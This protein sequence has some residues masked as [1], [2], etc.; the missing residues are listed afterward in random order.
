MGDDERADGRYRLAERRFSTLH[1]PWCYCAC[2]YF[3]SVARK[4]ARNSL[5]SGLDVLVEMVLPPIMS[6]IVARA[7]GPAKLG[8]FSYIVWLS[9]TAGMLSAAGIGRAANTFMAEYAGKQRP[10]V[11]RALLRT[12]V[13]FAIVVQAFITLLAVFWV[14]LASP[15]DERLFGSL[16]MLSIFPSGLMC[17]AT[18]VNNAVEE[19]RPNVVA[20]I[21]SGLVHTAGLLLVLLLDW[22]LVGLAA[23]MLASR[24]CDC[25]VR[26]KL[27]Y[28]RLPSYLKAMGSDPTPPGQKPTLPP[29]L[30]RQVAVFVAEA[31]VLT[32]LN[33][34][35]WN[36]SEMFFLKRYAPIEQVAYFSVAFGLSVLPGQLVGPFSRAAGVSV[37][38]ERGRD[39]R[40]GLRVTQV[41][42]RYLVLLVMPTCFGLS[43]LSGPFLRVLYG[44]RYFDAAPVLMWAGALSI[45][46]P[47]ASPATALITA[48]GGQRWLVISGLGTAVA[49]LTLDYVLVRG[50]A[51]VG[52]ALANGLGQAIAT[53]VT[54][55]IA[56]RYSFTFSF[57]YLVRVVAAALGMTALVGA[58]AH[59]LPDVAAVV[60]GPVVGA[61]AYCVLLR[62]ARIVTPEDVDRLLQAAPLLPRPLAAQFKRLV[63]AVATPSAQE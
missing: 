59:L 57:N 29:G 49:T 33:M 8:S 44:A 41:Y 15:E 2:P 43:V 25:A 22:G 14:N 47:L 3:M 27:T 42:W 4:I 39:A 45:F 19:L 11:F 6:I 17:V 58:T 48:A 9:T 34:V 7:M 32:L 40:A 1:S 63:H 5:W 26:W 20:S 60:V 54:I 62:V 51:A 30:G 18:S 38:A 52:G 46:A 31:A 23:S 53:V 56:R 36:R 28:A 55:L 12:S 10:D 24:T 13:S 61:L 16:A 37:Y 21:S 50:H 35:I